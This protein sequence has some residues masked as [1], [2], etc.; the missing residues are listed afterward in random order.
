VVVTGD[1]QGVGY[2]WFT[3]ERAH[4]HG[5]AGWVRNRH[6][7]AVEALAGGE[8]DRVDAFLESLRAG[9]R[10]RDS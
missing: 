6:D 5:V 3:R 4:E 8:H 10:V 1:V 2:R 7:G 9:G